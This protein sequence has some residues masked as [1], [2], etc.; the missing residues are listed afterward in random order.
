[1]RK[2]YIT[3]TM[4]LYEVSAT[5]W[6]KEKKESTQSVEY[7]NGEYD[8]EK[9]LAV[10]AER[11]NAILLSYEIEGV[12]TRKCAMEVVKFFVNADINEVIESEEE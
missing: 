6:D 2:K 11:N 1:M 8:I 10:V 5:F 4:K 7:I 12:T 3:R 9:Y